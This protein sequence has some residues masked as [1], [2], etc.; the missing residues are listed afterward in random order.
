MKSKILAVA[1]T[2]LLLTANSLAAQ[3]TTGRKIE[4]VGKEV[5]KADEA[6]EKGKKLVELFKKKKKNGQGQGEKTRTE[7]DPSIE[8]QVPPEENEAQNPIAQSK[9]K[10]EKEAAP[11]TQDPNQLK[12]GDVHPDA[13]VLDVD[14]MTPFSKGAAV[15]S[16]GRATALINSKGKIKVPFNSYFFHDGLSEVIDNSGF[17]IGH[18]PNKSP[19]KTIISDAHGNVLESPGLPLTIEKNGN[20][21]ELKKHNEHSEKTFVNIKGESLF[22]LTHVSEPMSCYNDGLIPYNGESAILNNQ[23]F[24]KKGYK[25]IKDQIIIPAQWEVAECFSEGAAIVGNRNEFGEMKYGFVNTEGKIIVLLKFSKKPENFSDGLAKIYSTE[26]LRPCMGRLN[27]SYMNK[28]GEF[29]INNTDFEEPC[30]IYGN[31]HFGNV[32][33]YK[34]ILDK[35]GKIISAKDFLLQFGIPSDIIRK[36]GQLIYND[37]DIVD[38]K[39]LISFEASEETTSKWYQA[40]LDLKNKTTLFYFKANAKISV[41]DPVSKLAFVQEYGKKG[42]AKLREGYINEEGI[43]MIVKGEA[44]KW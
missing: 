19:T 11:I 35:Q 15:I 26:S 25:N 31:F 10:T 34:F 17:F 33:S 39:I 7:K 41:F 36:N 38:G 9:E 29:V 32:V 21:I 6:L 43:F 28:N 30:S 4:K 8:K 2:L 24:V 18:D 20:Y 13:V 44:S 16:R 23:G 42:N 22:K 3:S 37:D 14:R 40:Y 1:M 27:Y 5:E 12:P